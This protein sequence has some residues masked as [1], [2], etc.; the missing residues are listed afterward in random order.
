MI[1]LFSY[2]RSKVCFARENRVVHAERAPDFCGAVRIQRFGA[3]RVDFAEKNH[4]KT[5]EFSV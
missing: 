2:C 5:Y 1:A 3:L 4:L